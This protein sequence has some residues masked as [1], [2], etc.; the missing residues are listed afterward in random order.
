MGLLKNNINIGWYG[1]C[2]SCSD[3]D[4]YTA[5]ST[6]KPQYENLIMV[7]QVGEQGFVYKTWTQSQHQ[8]QILSWDALPSSVHDAVDKLSYIKS[9]Q[10]I[11]KLVCGTPYVVE[12]QEG[13]EITIP[14]FTLSSNSGSGLSRVIE[15]FDC[16]TFPPCVCE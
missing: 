4:L 7:M 16:P 8:K 6:V 12:I 9:G 2:D 1:G 5:E 10:S 13:T 11:T 15:C 14:G 3:L